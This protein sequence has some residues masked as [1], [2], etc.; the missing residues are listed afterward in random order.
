MFGNA[1]G[2]VVEVDPA[3][4]L[5]CKLFLQ[6]LFFLRQ[7]LQGGVVTG[8]AANL[9]FGFLNLF[10]QLGDDLVNLLVLPLLF[11]RK[12]QLL[13]LVPSV[14]LFSIG[15]RC[16]GLLFDSFLL[17]YI[18]SPFPARTKTWFISLSKK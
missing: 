15:D 1:L 9:L 5:L 17:G 14:A 11:K 6:L 3:L 4:H 10:F 13:P 2:K 16:S 12:L 8:I 7:L 18:G